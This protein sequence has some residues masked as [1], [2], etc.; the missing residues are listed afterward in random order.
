MSTLLEQYQ[1]L[2]DTVHGGYT[3]GPVD[4]YQIPPYYFPGK[5][6]LVTGANQGIGRHTSIALAR[7]GA[8]VIVTSRSKGG[9]ET[10]DMI[11]ADSKCREAGGEVLSVDGGITN[12]MSTAGM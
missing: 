1:Y 5:V 12:R 11:M 8:T 9:P 3:H 4:D 6:A 10:V 2:P 7:C